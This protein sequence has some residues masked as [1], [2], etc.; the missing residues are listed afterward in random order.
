MGNN[1]L[2]GTLQSEF[3]EVKS[4]LVL[5]LQSN[6]ISGTIPYQFGSIES[7]SKYFKRWKICSVKWVLSLII[8][9][10]PQIRCDWKTIKSQG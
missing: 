9:G 10:S 8:A 5:R 3:G 7:L 1:K 2:T 4:L 6:K